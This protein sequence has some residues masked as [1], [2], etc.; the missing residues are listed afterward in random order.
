[1]S[2]KELLHNFSTTE[3]TEST[4]RCCFSLCPL[5]AGMKINNELVTP[6]ELTPPE[7]VSVR[8]SSVFFSSSFMNRSS[9]PTLWFF[10]YQKIRSLVN[11][12]TESPQRA[13]SSSIPVITYEKAAASRF[14]TRM[15]RIARIFTDTCTLL[16]V[17]FFEFIWLGRN[18]K[19]LETLNNLYITSRLFN[20]A[21]LKKSV[22]E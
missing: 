20:P 7:F 16:K 5:C 14:R 17:H 22:V 21:R 13:Q 9:W 1:M 12:L 19:I 4:E 11:G 8:F 6:Y 2:N 3:Y 15:T 10:T 18:S